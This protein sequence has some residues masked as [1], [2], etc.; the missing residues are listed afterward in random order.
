MAEQQIKRSEQLPENTWKLEDIYES[1]AA[2]EAEYETVKTRIPQIKTF[3]GRLGDIS[4]LREA[5]DAM[6]DMDRMAASLYTYAKMRLDE[7]N[8][9][10]A[11]QALFSRAQELATQCS[12]AGA[13]AVPELL[14]MP[15]SYILDA[16]RDP[17]LADYSMYLDDI[18]RRKAHTLSAAEEKL[19]AMAGELAAAPSNIFGMLNNADMK[20][21]VIKD[22]NGEDARVTHANY[23]PFLMNRSESVRKAAFE[24]MYSTYAS[25]NATVPAIYAA[26]V[27]KDVFFAK[28]GSI[29]AR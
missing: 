17:L 16:A 26:S 10:S 24:A 27:K 20:F 18:A 9:V 15:D 22:E 5:L 29:I 14:S 3:E 4:V 2:W 23:I 6:F 7:D 19:L 1:L 8:T 21:P 13:F 25:Y 12:V 11:C 28:A